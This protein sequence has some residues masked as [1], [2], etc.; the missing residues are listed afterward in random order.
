MFMNLMMTMM[1]M[2]VMMTTE[3]YKVSETDFTVHV[4]MFPTFVWQ[5]NRLNFTLTKETTAD[6]D[7]EFI[8]SIWTPDF[9]IYHL[10]ELERLNGPPP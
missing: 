9:Y 6:L 4:N 8:R 5:D 1:A 10:Q 3:I 2:M 7:E